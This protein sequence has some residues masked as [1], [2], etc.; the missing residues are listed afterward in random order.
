MRVTILKDTNEIE[1]A[2][3]TNNFLNQILESQIKE[4]QY[5][6]VNFSDDDNAKNVIMYTVLVVTSDS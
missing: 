6:T 4:L 3:K 2:S 1:L 5:S